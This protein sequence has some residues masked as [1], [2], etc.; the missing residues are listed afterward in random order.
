MSSTGTRETTT[1]FSKKTYTES[2]DGVNVGTV[3]EIFKVVHSKYT[4]KDCI[5]HIVNN[6]A[7]RMVILELFV[8]SETVL[9]IK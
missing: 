2:A 6:G 5:Q 8:V 4:N 1:M 3:E 7:K 9:N